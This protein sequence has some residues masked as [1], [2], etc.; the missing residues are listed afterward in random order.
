M[1]TGSASG[2]AITVDGRA[3]P[4]LRG[5]VQSNILLD[6]D[7]LLA[8]TAIVRG[9]GVRTP[10]PPAPAPEPVPPAPSTD[11]ADESAVEHPE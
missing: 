2:L 4:A 8:G 10:V 7:R 3:A 11:P 1:R 6:P 5:G 9:A